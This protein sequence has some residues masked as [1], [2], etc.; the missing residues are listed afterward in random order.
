MR[1]QRKQYPSCSFTNPSPKAAA[2]S[3]SLHPHR[4]GGILRPLP[5]SLL[6]A[7]IIKILS[8]TPRI[9]HRGP[10]RRQRSD[11]FRRRARARIIP[12]RRVFSITGRAH[13][14]LFSVLL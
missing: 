6:S 2:A 8:S 11:G 9:R 10:S 7:L 14:V 1:E 3:A 12:R 13:C 4:G 5:R